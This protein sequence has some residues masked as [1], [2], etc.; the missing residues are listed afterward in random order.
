MNKYNALKV[1]LID[2]TI[3]TEPFP[4]AFRYYDFLLIFFYEK[5]VE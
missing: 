5:L 4:M 1:S 3:D 2:C